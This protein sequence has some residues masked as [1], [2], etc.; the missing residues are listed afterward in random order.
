LQFVSNAPYR[1]KLKPDG[2]VNLAI[3]LIR[4]DD[5]GDASSKE[6]IEALTAEMLLSKAPTLSNVFELKV[7]EI[8][9]QDHATHTRGKLVDALEQLYPGQTFSIPAIYRALLGEITARNNN[10]EPIDSFDVL[11]RKKSLSRSRFSEILKECG[12]SKTIPKWATAEQ[13]LIADQAPFPLIRALEREW[14]GVLLDRL[15]RR[16]DIIYVRMRQAIRNA[17]EESKHHPT[18]LQIVNDGMT[19]LKRS[20][21]WSYT[22]IYLKT[23]ILVQT[24]ES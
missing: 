15:E 23:C 3:N 12:I 13:N 2:K 9:L 4:F 8:S 20:A 24:Y 11:L 6:L 16:G 10:S 14:D 22:E 21:D 1:I 5:L 18:L 19:N 7:S 17:V